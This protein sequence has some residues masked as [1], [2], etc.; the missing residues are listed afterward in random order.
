MEDMAAVLF[1]VGIV[2]GDGRGVDCL[3]RVEKLGYCRGI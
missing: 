2:E 1:E 3:G